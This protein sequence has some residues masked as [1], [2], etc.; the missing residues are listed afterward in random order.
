MGTECHDSPIF[1]V[2]ASR[3]GTELMRCTL[4]QHPSVCISPETHYFD[5]L[6]IKLRGKERQAL[7]RTEAR[8]CE[9][10]FLAA[11]HRPYGQ[12]GRPDKATL[13]REALRETAAKIGNGADAFFE[14][15]CQMNARQR[16][17]D[18]WG[19][20]TPRHV[21]CL[22]QIFAA[23]PRSKVIC[24]VRDP[25]GVVASYRDL[26]GRKSLDHDKD[27]EGKLAL[28]Q[29]QGRF[30][31][32]YNILIAC[33]LWSGSVQAALEARRRF[34]ADRVLIQRY[35]DLVL[36]P[37]SALAR[38]TAWLSIDYC[39]AMR[40]AP[41]T[42]STYVSFHP[43][44]GFAKSSIDRWRTNLSRHEIA[45][46]QTSCRHVMRYAGYQLDPVS[47][48]LGPLLWECLKLP[49]AAINAAI[50]NRARIGA[51]GPYLY[52]RIRFAG[53]SL[54]ETDD[55]RTREFW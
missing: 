52:R 29:D 6:R 21:F 17:A 34:T 19:E 1:V 50:A 2:G 24:M 53:G 13:S 12:G 35:E 28:K 3:S 25:R 55:L 41:I 39:P 26:K 15:F 40:N 8:K 36:D 7:T 5:D 27:P 9:D 38:L 22:P 20:K 45:V 11:L 51:M 54:M 4:N 33:L 32:S 37:P 18:R 10:H 42:N 43:S 14:A 44:A 23:F 46:I 49:A 48:P 47:T 30:Q 16:G 31:R